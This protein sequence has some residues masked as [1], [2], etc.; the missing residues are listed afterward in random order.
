MSAARVLRYKTPN[1]DRQSGETARLR[2]LKGPDYGIIHVIRSNIVNIGRGEDVD[3]IMA[4]MK[5]SRKHARLELTAE[6]WILSD[7]SSGNGILFEGKVVQKCLLKEMSTFVIGETVFEFIPKETNVQ[8]LK[9]PLRSGDEILHQEGELIRQRARLQNI[10]N[11]IEIQRKEETPEAKKKRTVLLLVGVLAMAYMYQDDII[12]MFKDPPKQSQKKKD[13]NA[14]KALANDI[15]AVEAPAAIEKTAEQFFREG[16]REYREGKYLRA[17]NQF[18]LALEVNPA[19][20]KAKLYLGVV[21]EEIKKESKSLLDRAQQARAIG[22]TAEAKGYYEDVKRL[23]YLDQENPK[24]LQAD[25]AVKKI[26][27]EH[28]KGN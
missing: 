25:E 4:D 16:F 3:V 17:K 10:G 11:G 8:T 1:V 2:I 21:E 14:E 7:I 20:G 26:E 19:H 22:R 27:E 24:Y 15:P 9:S 13:P 18:E 6:G 23:L 28:K 5:A 12:K